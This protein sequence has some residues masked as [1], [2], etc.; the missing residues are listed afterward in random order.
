MKTS[1][2]K[3]A[4]WIVA[5][6]VL[7]G[8]VWATPVTLTVSPSAI[9]NTYSGVI[10][11][12]IGGLT[13]TEKV[14]VQKW[15]DG[16]ANGLIDAGELLMEQG[17]ITDGGAMVIGG[18]TNINVPFDSNAT[19][20]AITAALNCPPGIPLEN[21]VGHYVFVVSSATGRFSPVTATFQITNDALNQFIRG[22][23]YSNGVPWPYAVVG[24]Q[25]IQVNNLPGAAMPDGSGHYVMALSPGT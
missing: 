12:N 4:V 3:S 25:D 17:N 10:T 7:A 23:I 22:I 21:M 18:I 2:K 9:S 8:N 19:T 16:N 13:N 14:V 5:F 11:L 1:S 20:G 24:A 15:Q 6:A